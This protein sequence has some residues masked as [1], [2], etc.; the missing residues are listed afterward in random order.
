MWYNRS[1][2]YAV[3]P[4]YSCSP[5]VT[6]SPPSVVLGVNPLLPLGGANVCFLRDRVP[7]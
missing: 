4:P 2:Y 1:N 7:V 5:V 6:Y 3:A